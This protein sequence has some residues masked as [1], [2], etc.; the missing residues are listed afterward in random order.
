MELIENIFMMIIVVFLS[1]T[2]FHMI[3]DVMGDYAVI[4]AIPVAWLIGKTAAFV[5]NKLDGTE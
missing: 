1:T 4:V 3:Q 5:Q 2:A